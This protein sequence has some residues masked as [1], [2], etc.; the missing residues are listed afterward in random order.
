MNLYSN[1]NNI[2]LERKLTM[3]VVGFLTTFVINVLIVC[4]ITF[5]LSFAAT[6]RPVYPLGVKTF[7]RKKFGPKF[8][9]S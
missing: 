4:L 1:K 3:I 6:T 9:C 2:F 8:Y 7:G 5:R